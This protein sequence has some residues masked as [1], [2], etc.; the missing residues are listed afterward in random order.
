MGCGNLLF[1]VSV[2]HSLSLSLVAASHLPSKFFITLISIIKFI[3]LFT[4]DETGTLNPAHHQ[5]DGSMPHE[6]RIP[7]AE[8]ISNA[9]AASHSSLKLKTTTIPNVGTWC[10]FCFINGAEN[11]VEEPPLPNIDVVA[12]GYVCAISNSL[13]S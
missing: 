8:Q 11:D 7:N 9:R 1:S 3:V 13:H 10:R 12:L 2:S 6:Y 4:V 5:N